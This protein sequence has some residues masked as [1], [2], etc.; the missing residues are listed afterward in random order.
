MEAHG[1]ANRARGIFQGD[2]RF[3]PSSAIASHLGEA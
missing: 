2:L 3:N 1:A